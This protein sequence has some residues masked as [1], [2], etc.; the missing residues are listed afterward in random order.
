MN[1]QGNG[2]PITVS[3]YRKALEGV[4]TQFELIRFAL[5]HLSEVKKN[6]FFKQ[7]E[8][9]ELFELDALI[10]AKGFED[11]ENTLRDIM[12]PD[13]HNKHGPG[14]QHLSLEVSEDR[15]NQSELL[16]L[17]AHFESF[18]KLVHRTF[19]MASPTKVFGSRGT[20]VSLSKVFDP[21]FVHLNTNKFLNELIISSRGISFRNRGA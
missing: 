12:E 9:K 3:H 10:K 20:E 14:E 18:M 11:I 7:R 4:E 16:L 21:S 19:L 17:V 2:F 15:L 5:R 1:S 6:E 13:I 8:A